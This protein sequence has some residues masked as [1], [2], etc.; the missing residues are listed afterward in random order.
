MK[1]NECGMEN[2]ADARFCSNCGT[3]LI[4]TAVRRA[5]KQGAEE[6]AFTNDARPL[7]ENP[8]RPAR[9]VIPNRPVTPVK[10]AKP[11][12]N[13][14]PVVNEPDAQETEEQEED[15]LF[16]TD[17]EH[18]GGDDDI[19]LI[20]FDDEGSPW[21]F[22]LII[23]GVTLTILIVAAIIVYNV[24]FAKPTA[25]GYIKQAET[26]MTAGRLSEAAKAYLNAFY[27]RSDD[28]DL[29]LKAARGL[30]KAGDYEKA[31]KIC[32]RLI[33]ISPQEDGAY[34]LLLAL[35]TEQDKADLIRAFPAYRHAMQNPNEALA[36]AAT[37]R[38]AAP[39]PSVPG[40]TYT[41]PVELMITAPEGAEIR[42]TLDGSDPTATSS[43]YMGIILIDSG[44][45]TIRAVAVKDSVVSEIWGGTYTVNQN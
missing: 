18:E 26:H 37:P 1:C 25:E 28:Y 29:C 4:P 22:R 19:N 21:T 11:Q 42:Y 2:I 15:G 12:V 35:F 43:I 7:K 40:G 31:E 24:F 3:K 16:E 41:K 13:A 34:D 36:P 9:L 39:V 32:L 20:D 38:L 14:A 27:A 10:P 44:T 33:D 5:V 6:G 8:V 23:G 45:H 30:G 17:D